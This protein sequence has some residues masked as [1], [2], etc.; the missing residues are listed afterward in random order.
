VYFLFLNRLEATGV[1]PAIVGG[2]AYGNRVARKLASEWPQLVRGVVLIAAGGKLAPAPGVFESLRTYQDKSLP[3]EKRADAARKI[4]YGPDSNVSITDMHMD[5]VSAT[6]IRT[7]SSAAPL[8]RGAGALVVPPQI[9]FVGNARKIIDLAARHNIPAIYPGRGF[10]ALGGLMSYA[11]DFTAAVRQTGSHYAAQILRGAKPAE[12]P[13]Q[14]PTKFE[15]IINL[16]TAKTLGLTIPET[17]LAI[18][19]EVIQ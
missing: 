18:A 8:E 6:T 7:Q 9:L 3:I 11:A 19:D 4:F 16:K 14:Q 13:V 12:L 1:A 17:L 15:L 5:E 10:V 2:W